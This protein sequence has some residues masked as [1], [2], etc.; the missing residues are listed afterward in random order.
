MPMEGA[1][2]VE[3]QQRIIARLTDVQDAALLETIER[4]IEEY[5]AHVKLQRLREDEVD[6]ILQV[7]LESD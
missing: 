3:R 5:L 4:L 7:L 1:G 2:L 6:A